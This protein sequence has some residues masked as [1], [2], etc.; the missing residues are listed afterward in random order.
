[1]VK[2]HRTYTIEEAAT[3]TGVA[4]GTVARW[5]KSGKLPALK[6]RR[7]YLIQGQELIAFL[8]AGKTPNRR[9]RLHEAYC[10]SCRE[11]REPAGNMAD[12][13]AVSA[14]IGDLQAL[15]ANC[16]GVMH[17]RVSLRDQAALEALLDLTVRQASPRIGK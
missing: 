12:L 9:C 8:R 5:L 15:C 2:K 17:K 13:V 10:F 16:G 6:D 14:S 11:V 3:K 1:L 7:P 4:K